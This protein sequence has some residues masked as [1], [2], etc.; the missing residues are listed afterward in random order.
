MDFL[1]ITCK[2]AG[3]ALWVTVLQREPTCPRP[4][5]KRELGGGTW[6]WTERGRDGGGAGGE[7]EAKGGGAWVCFL[8]GGGG[9]CAVPIKLVQGAG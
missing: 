3:S 1:R 2:A 8:V 9:G 6:V 5:L 7:E 4:P